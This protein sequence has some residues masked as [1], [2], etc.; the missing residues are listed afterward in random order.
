[1]RKNYK[2]LIKNVGILTIGNFTTKLLNF[3]LIPLYTAVLTT[4]EYGE[5]DI[6]NTTIGLL[7]PIFTLNIFEGI[8]RYALD[9]SVDI[10]TLL[11]VALKYFFLGLIP[12]GIFLAVNM[13]VN[14][15]PIFNKYG[16]FFVLMYIFNA[17]SAILTSIA[18]GMEN[19]KIV[20][21]SGVLS[22]LIVI[23]SNI[24]L[25]LFFELGIS[26]YF[27]ANISGTAMQCVCILLGIRLWNF[28]AVIFRK[29]PNLKKIENNILGYSIP[30]IANSIGWWINN[31]SDRFFVTFFCGLSI[32]GIYSI[33]YKIPTFLNV[34]VSIF[35]QAWNLSAIKDFNSKDKDGFF[36]K[37]YSIYNCFMVLICSLIILCNKILAGIFYSNNFYS[38]WKFV[39]FLLIAFYFGSI[40]G[41]IGAIFSAVK[42]SDIYA[43][44][45]A[46]GAVVNTVLNFILVFF[47]GAMGAAIATMIS[48]FSVWV[49]R[50]YHMKQFIQI[51]I[52]LRR[53]LI[54]YVFLV[55]QA[56]LMIIMKN[57]LCM[58]IIQIILFVI[59]IL[60]FMRDIEEI[61]KSI[62]LKSRDK[63]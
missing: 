31:V 53:D 45:T 22:S 46:I 5:F 35:N 26:G 2:Y 56:I 16:L 15:I 14:I 30:L 38:A 63:K 13:Q 61:L 43:K 60:L 33:A 8:F 39:P 51:Q 29:N 18:K 52:K 57:N 3:F 55:A 23:L 1:M 27:I 9:N 50:Y 10:G 41:Y 11:K 21:L 40:S 25:L 24:V 62:L 34:L 54:S 36:S 19:L 28:R 59:I 42:R 12:L 47:I 37:I 48:Y 17:L 49:I 44:S 58:Y 6:I 7:V 32:N 4:T 20:A